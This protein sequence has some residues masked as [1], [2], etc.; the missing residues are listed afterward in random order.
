MYIQGWTSRCSLGGIGTDVV[1]PNMG[2]AA[3]DWWMQ[4]MNGVLFLRN[5][6]DTT[7]CSGEVAWVRYGAVF[8]GV[9]DALDALDPAPLSLLSRKAASVIGREH[10]LRWAYIG[11]M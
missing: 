4:L 3:A 1:F 6:T 9:N 5:A 8:G 11:R 2:R 10:H 7:G